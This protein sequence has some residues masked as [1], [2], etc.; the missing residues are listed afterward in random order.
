MKVGPL[1][2]NGGQNS[3]SIARIQE[4][5]ALNGAELALARAANAARAGNRPLEAPDA[6]SLPS[7]VHP[8]Q[9]KFL[10]LR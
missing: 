7:N 8:N 3:A 1:R 9:E 2:A 6:V 10:P 5:V 4:N